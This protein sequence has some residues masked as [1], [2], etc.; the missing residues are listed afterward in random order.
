MIKHFEII[1]NHIQRVNIT[2]KGARHNSAL[3][4]GL[5]FR[6]RKCLHS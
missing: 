6:D 3:L 1:E 2:I 4:F 5:L